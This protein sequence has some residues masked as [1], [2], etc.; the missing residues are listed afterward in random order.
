MAEHASQQHRLHELP[1]VAV[2]SHRSRNHG[3]LTRWIRR[4]VLPQHFLN[5]PLPLGD[6]RHHS[7]SYRVCDICL[8]RNRQRIGSTR[9]EPGLRGLLST[10]LFGL[11]EGSG[12]K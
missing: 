3:G 10:R 11:A 7:S 4:R 1:P 9:Y 6:V 2:D 12:R 5:V 8:C